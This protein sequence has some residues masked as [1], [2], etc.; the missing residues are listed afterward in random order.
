M[1]RKLFTVSQANKA[2]PRIARL[3]Q[4]LQEKFVWLNTH[5]RPA[6][7]PAGG[8]EARVAERFNIV[9]ESPVEPEYFKALLTVRRDLKEIQEAGAQVKDI[10][11]GLVDFPARLH[12]REVLLCWRLGEDRIRFWHDPESGFA[13]RQPLPAEDG[14]G[15]EGPGN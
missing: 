11:T 8:P 2:I 10:N 13:G 3:V 9:D 14:S 1:E 6:P 12:G 4:D 7:D 15:S 5:H